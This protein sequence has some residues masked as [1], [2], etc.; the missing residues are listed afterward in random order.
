MVSKLSKINAYCA[1]GLF[2]VSVGFLF[3]ADVK[4]GISFIILS[5]FMNL[6]AIY[7]TLVDDKNELQMRDLIAK[8]VVFVLQV[9]AFNYAFAMMQMATTL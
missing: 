5:F 7:S 2:V 8:G 3:Y 1:W 9:I 6:A 4:W